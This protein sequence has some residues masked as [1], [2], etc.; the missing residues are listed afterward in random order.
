M[1]ER[2]K[3]KKRIE[4]V[5]RPDHKVSLKVRQVVTMLLLKWLLCVEEI[6]VNKD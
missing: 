5:W 6:G 4:A 2:K 3:K 1:K